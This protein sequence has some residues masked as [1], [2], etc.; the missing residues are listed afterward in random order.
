MK[1]LQ[2]FILSLIVGLLFSGV[3]FAATNVSTCQVINSP[4]EYVL[5][6][7]LAGAPVAATPSGTA[8]IRV[9]TSDVSLDCAGYGITNNGTADPTAGIN[10]GSGVSNVTVMNCPNVAEFT[11]GFYIAASTDVTLRNNT[12]Y[13]NTQHGFILL[14]NANNNL[15]QNNSAIDNG[16]HGFRSDSS[17][18]NVYTDNTATGNAQYGFYLVAS[19]NS[20]NYTNNVVSG[21]TNGFYIDDSGFNRFVTN[22]VSSTTSRAIYTTGTSSNNLFYSNVLSGGSGTGMQL[23]GDGGFNNITGNTVY[24]YSQSG[25]YLSSS[26]NNTIS[27]N[28]ASSNNQSGIHLVSSHNN[29]VDDNTVSN[30]MYYG[31]RFSSSHDNSLLRNDANGNGNCEPTTYHLSQLSLSGEWSELFSSPFTTQY[32]TKEFPFTKIGDKIS[33]RI[34][35]T[36]PAPFAD[37]EAI[38]LS[39]CGVDLVPT[40]AKYVDTGESV[41]EDILAIDYNVIV[42]HDKE[43]ELSW[44]IPASCNEPASLYL[45]ANEY[46]DGLPMFFPDAGFATV[47]QNTAVPAIDGLIAETDGIENPS[48]TVLWKPHSGH[49]E[50]YT[51]IYTSQDSNNVYISLDITSDNTNE[52]GLDWAEITFITSSGEKSFK[53]DDYNAEYGKCGFGLTSKVSY[54]HQTCEFSIPKNEIGDEDLNFM[55]EYYGTESSTPSAILLSSSSRNVVQG[56]NMSQTACGYGSYIYY[57]TYN[58]YTDNIV[59]GNA[60]Y[61]YFLY[62]SNNTLVTRDRFFNNTQYDFYAYFGSDPR[63][64]NLS[65]VI[66][67]NPLGNL[68]NY[69]TLS[70]YDSVNESATYSI[71][72]AALPGAAPKTSVAQKSINITD[73]SGSPILDSITWHWSEGEVSGFNENTF[74][75]WEYNSS[76]NWSD[77]GAALSTAAN[78][79]NLAN[80]DPGGI[81]SILADTVTTTTSSGGGTSKKSLT[82]T[83]GQICPGDSIQVNVTSSGSALENAEV[84]LIYLLTYNVTDKLTNSSG[85]TIFSAQN[86]GDYKLIVSKSKY[87]SQEQTFTYTACP[88]EEKPPEPPPVEPP[89]VIPPPV[90]ITIPPFL[91]VTDQLLTDSLVDIYRAYLG[92]PGCIVL[93]LV[94]ADGSPGAV[95]GMSDVISGNNSDLAIN[96]INYDNETELMAMLYYDDGDGVCDPDKDAPATVDGTPVAVNFKLTLPPAAPPVEPPKPPVTEEP[97]VQ[98]PKEGDDLFGLL[99]IIF[100]LILI[101]GGAGALY[102]KFGRKS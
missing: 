90:N 98:P 32:S 84:R 61:G 39:A 42:A 97:P 71:S 1:T 36:G 88:K 55:L 25:I 54:K 56:N 50:G 14:S 92:E 58:N 59:N 52:Y 68:V 102:W 20:S 46:L 18:F 76:G 94:N 44:D 12:G 80:L 19:S 10:V 75:I 33:V 13:N 99:L 26:D 17:S 38:Q 83:Y 35:Q 4:G 79:L 85:S 6:V 72:W 51:Y 86:P 73:Q 15:I 81:Y 45:T 2:I 11:H 82:A 21:G 43:I 16:F 96:L 65:Q 23:N 74:S 47:S 93:H 100:L 95:V 34:V 87:H 49:P 37:V 8:C 3:S 53:I 22:N 31:I 62:N 89:P 91:N 78:T 41:L 29:S 101:L 70:L 28:N 69:T 60:Y 67:D 40:Y 24:G 66:F 57:S 30:N 48:Y 5:N 7:S 9:N 63:I 77:K 27:S 64:L